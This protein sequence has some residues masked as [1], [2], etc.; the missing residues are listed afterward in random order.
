MLALGSPASLERR[1]C[2]VYSP[3][4]L[5]A[6][7]RHVSGA[8]VAHPRSTC[9]SLQSGRCVSLG[10]R[11]LLGRGGRAQPSEVAVSLSITLSWSSVPRG[12]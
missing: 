1:L 7:P 11:V 9:L 2:R 12:W 6:G 3:W 8:A 4:G 10:T 5:V